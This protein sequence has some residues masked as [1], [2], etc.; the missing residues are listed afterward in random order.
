[1]TEYDQRSYSRN[2][3]RLARARDAEARATSKVIYWANKMAKARLTVRAVQARMEKL[4]AEVTKES[5][6]AAL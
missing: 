4:E 3:S 1:M 5:I 2:V 6:K